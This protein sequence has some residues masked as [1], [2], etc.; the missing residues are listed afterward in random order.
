MDDENSDVKLAL[1]EMRLNMQQSLDAGDA[2]DQKVNLIL[3][4]AGLVIALGATLQISFSPNRSVTYWIILSIVVVLYIVSVAAALL[5]VN[6]Q[7]YRMAIASDWNEL[8]KRIFEK[9]ERQAILALLSGY[10]EQIQHNRQINHRKVFLLRFCLIG[11]VASV[12]LMVILVLV[13]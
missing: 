7:N 13:R 10:V 1:E 12:V 11:L 5:A 2:L 3:A 8:D 9:K 4:V 6:P